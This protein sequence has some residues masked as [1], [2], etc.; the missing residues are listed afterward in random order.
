MEGKRDEDAWREVLAGNSAVF[1]VIWDRHRDPVF[2]HLMRLG[3]IAADAEDLT[4]MVFLEL[5]RRRK[6]VRFV[7]GSLLPWLLV[8]AQNVARNAGRARR[9]YRAFLAKLPPPD[10][11]D[12]PADLFVGRQLELSD[13]AA[14]ILSTSN[15]TDRAL[16][17]LTAIEGFTVRDAAAAVGISEAAAKMRLSRLRTRVRAAT[18]DDSVT[19]E[20]PE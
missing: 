6:A 7:D 16:L 11:A 15:G 13:E 3:V 17:A 20:V 14:R 10:V 8:T 1:G 4:A 5:W 19:K 9:R 2:R 18:I 12:D